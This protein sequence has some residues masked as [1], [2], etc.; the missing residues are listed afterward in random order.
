MEI[1][2]VKVPPVDKKKQKAR[3]FYKKAATEKSKGNLSEAVKWLQKSVELDPNLGDAHF[4]LSEFYIQMG[5][6]ETGL[7]SATRAIEC[8]AEDAEGYNN[9]G[10]ASINLNKRDDAE[11]DFVKAV[12]LAPEFAMARYNLGAI[13]HITGRQDLAFL[14]WKEFLKL[15]PD[16]ER[17]TDVRNIMGMS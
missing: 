9:R 17:A 14:H 15:N 6:Y 11:K 1:E 16:S 2:T 7:A 5:Q 8:N 3:R 12:E 13:Y 4:N 10:I